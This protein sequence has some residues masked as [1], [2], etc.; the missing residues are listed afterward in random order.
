MKKLVITLLLHVP[1]AILN[2]VAFID[3]KVFR[4]T[5]I[6]VSMCNVLI[7]IKVVQ[8]IYFFVNFCILILQPYV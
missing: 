1:V 6:P 4:N 2:F 3:A 5:S 7:A 8:M